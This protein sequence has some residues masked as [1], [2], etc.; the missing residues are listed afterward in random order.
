MRTLPKK[1]ALLALATSLALGLAA[2]GSDDED[3]ASS[4]GGETSVSSEPVAEIASLSGKQTAVTLDAGFVQGVTSLGLTPGVVGGATFDGATGKVAFPITG[5]NVTYYDP[6]SDVEPYVQ[7]RIE[8]FQSGLTLSKGGT[9]VTLRN[10]VVDPGESMLLGKVLVNGEPFPAD[11]SEVP[12]FFLDGRTLKPLMPG[13]EPDTA[14]LE[15]TVVKL[16]KTAADALNMVF[17]T[18][19]LTEFF[20]VGVAEIT[21]NTA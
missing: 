18:D 13:T 9:T 7:G 12:L 10:F 15:G 6:A 14:V 5:G 1:A 8:H 20:T 16:T 21:V 2:C 17:M 11:G 4:S 3:T 19:A